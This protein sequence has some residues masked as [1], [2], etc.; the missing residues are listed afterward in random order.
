MYFSVFGRSADY[1]RS[2]LSVIPVLPNVVDKREITLI[3]KLEY[4][5]CLVYLLCQMRFEFC[6]DSQELMC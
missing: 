6:D 1:L 5:K 2:M 3:F 4:Y